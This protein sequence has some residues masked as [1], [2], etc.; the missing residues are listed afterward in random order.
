M[1]K[2]E[3]YFVSARLVKA[4]RCRIC[5]HARGDIEDDEGRVRAFWLWEEIGMRVDERE[6]E[7]DFGDGFG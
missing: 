6:V 1:L 2:T 3:A 7:A 4:L 5:R